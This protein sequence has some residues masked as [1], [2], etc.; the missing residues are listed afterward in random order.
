MPGMSGA[1]PLA[2]FEAWLLALWLY[3]S[4]PWGSQGEPAASLLDTSVWV[5][6][7]HCL[8]GGSAG[9]PP[10]THPLM[11]SSFSPKFLQD[12]FDLDRQS[13]LY[14]L[15]YRTQK[16]SN[17][18]ESGVLVLF[19]PRHTQKL[20]VWTIS[21]LFILYMSGFGPQAISW[22]SCPPRGK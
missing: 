11:S 21:K 13:W 17:V 9:W 7:S 6:D 19:C 5:W 15:S 8:L 12:S 1:S 22:L 18:V 14:L 16:L 4:W 2:L 20:N 3:G 10:S